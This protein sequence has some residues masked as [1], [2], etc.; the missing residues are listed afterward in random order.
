MIHEQLIRQIEWLGQTSSFI[1][2]KAVI[3]LHRPMSDREPFCNE[4]KSIHQGEVDVVLYP[5]PTIQAI[6]NE[7]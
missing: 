6:I 2:L 3:E 5:C 1:A 7:L 4:C